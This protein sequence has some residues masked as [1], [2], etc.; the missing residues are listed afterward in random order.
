[1]SKGIPAGFNTVS[2][3]L[4]VS[5]PKAALA[6]YEKAFGAVTGCCLEMPD[7]KVM[8]AEMQ[9]GNSTVMLGGEC[10]EYGNLSPLALKG[11]PVT[12]HIYVD[13]V[14]ES[15][16]KAI[17]A[18]AKEKMPVTDMF[19]GDRY[20]QVTDPY[21]HTWSLATHMRDVSPEEL[22]AGAEECMKKMAQP[23]G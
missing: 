16:K 22:K 10:K 8:H 7:G 23:V 12:L 6:F 2:A 21:G 4:V 18:G 11:S 1:M 5:D 15:F 19:W 13:N 14:D 3:H 17:S 9:I 20:G